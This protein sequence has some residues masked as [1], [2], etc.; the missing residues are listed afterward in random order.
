M[1]TQHVLHVFRSLDVPGALDIGF[2]T[3]GRWMDAPAGNFYLTEA[4]ANELAVAILNSGSADAGELMRLAS[5]WDG[6]ILLEKFQDAEGSY[7]RLRKEQDRE[8]IEWTLAHDE[9]L[10]LASMIQRETRAC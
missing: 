2:E 5:V 10:K 6:V 9:S 3:R 7:L 4:G 8:A 1:S